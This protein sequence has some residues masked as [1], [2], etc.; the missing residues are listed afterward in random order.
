[1]CLAQAFKDMATS[2][3]LNPKDPL[4][5]M[6]RAALYHELD[7]VRDTTSQYSD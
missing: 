3:K 6:V 1:M 7:Q 5:Y 4:N 2:I